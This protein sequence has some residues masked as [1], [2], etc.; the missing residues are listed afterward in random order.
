MYVITL[1]GYGNYTVVLGGVHTI[2]PHPS[3]HYQHFVPKNKILE[4]LAVV[5]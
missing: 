2:T 5:L 3:L 4:N 1:C